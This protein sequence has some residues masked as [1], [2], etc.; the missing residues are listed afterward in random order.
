MNAKKLIRI[1][2]DNYSMKKESI[3]GE[4]GCSVRSVERWYAGHGK[5]LPI[6]LDRLREIA[7]REYP[8]VK[9]GAKR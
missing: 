9:Q 6:Y 1:L 3:A 8:R 5:P 4:L 2:V 7:M